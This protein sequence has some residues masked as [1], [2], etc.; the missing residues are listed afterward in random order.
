[1]GVT[2]HRPCGG[3][4]SERGGT[5]ETADPPSLPPMSPPHAPCSPGRRSR[6]AADIAADAGTLLLYPF[7]PYLSPKAIGGSALCCRLASYWHYDQC[8]PAYGFAGRR[9]I[10]IPIWARSR[11]V[12]LGMTPAAA[13]HQSMQGIIPRYW[14]CYNG[15]DFIL[16]V[17]RSQHSEARIRLDGTD[18]CPLSF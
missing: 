8:A 10:W 7:T 4:A 17:F 1:M 5:N 12:P 2:H 9:S 13:Y 11:E 18:L 3:D 6:L 14:S 15:G 16:R